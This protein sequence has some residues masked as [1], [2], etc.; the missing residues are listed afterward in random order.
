MCL[1]HSHNK[2]RETSKCCPDP[3][4]D[5]GM[6]ENIHN[7]CPIH[8]DSRPF[9]CQLEY[10]Y[11][12]VND[13]WLLLPCKNINIDEMFAL[14][15][16]FITHNSRVSSSGSVETCDYQFCENDNILS[17]QNILNKMNQM[18]KSKK[19]KLSVLKK[20]WLEI[21]AHSRF[22]LFTFVHF[23]ILFLQIWQHCVSV[24][25]LR[26]WQIFKT[27]KECFV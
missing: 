3:L 12:P 13:Y 15:N 25:M 6:W 14:I 26:Q 24:N 5:P 10:F 22:I 8:H 9:Q 21:L 17:T 1:R 7:D 23:V 11:E 4:L 27:S 18:N 16:L 2:C 20:Q 19:S